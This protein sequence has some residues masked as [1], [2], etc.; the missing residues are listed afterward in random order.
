MRESTQ[1]RHANAM[2]AL[3]IRLES[4]LEVAEA[5][6]GDVLVVETEMRAFLQATR[7]IMATAS[8]STTA[9][10]GVRSCCPKCASHRISHSRRR[11]HIVT[12]EGE[13]QYS[14]VR[15]RCEACHCDFYPFEERNDLVGNQYTIGARTVIAKTATHMAY[16]PASENVGERGISV[17][18]KEVDRVAQEVAEWRR[19]DEKRVHGEVMSA[20]HVEDDEPVSVLPSWKGWARDT[21]AVLSV[22]GALLRSP[23]KGPQGAVW[24]ECRAAVI[25][26]ADDLSKA[27]H[28]HTAGVLDPDTI[29]EQ[30]YVG[31][32]SDWVRNRLAL[33]IADGAAWIW[34]RVARYF[35]DAIPVVDIY[36]V[37]E[38]VAEAAKAAWGEGSPQADHWQKTAREQLMAKNGPSR[39]RHILRDVLDNGIPVDRQTLNREVQYL[40][41]HKDRMPYWQLKQRGLPIG[42]GVMESAI[43]QVATTRLRGAGMKWTRTGADGMLTLRAAVLS[44]SLDATV[45]RRA[46]S[47]RQATLPLALAA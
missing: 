38:H 19:Q 32:Q 45:A 16:A 7:R 35:P 22:D 27:A 15:H 33:F 4:L 13:A 47:L 28:F 43:K 12:S 14:A 34:N 5:C 23:E 29:F 2:Q 42:S 24:F 31:W 17:S 40:Q 18:A 10:W 11:R 6:E 46:A 37:A 36:H 3:S 9:E 30:L 25:A 39:V 44:D 8:V 21:P 1:I 41:T 26:P 20:A